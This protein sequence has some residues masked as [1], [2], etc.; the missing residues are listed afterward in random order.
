MTALYFSP[1]FK[2]PSNYKGK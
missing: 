2:A 1:V